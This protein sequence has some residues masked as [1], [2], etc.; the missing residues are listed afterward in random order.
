MVDPNTGE[1][2]V[3]AV[4]TWGRRGTHQ[5]SE[6]GTGPGQYDRKFEPVSNGPLRA[7]TGKP[8]RR[9]RKSHSGSHGDKAETARRILVFANP[10]SQTA[11]ENHTIQVGFDN[12]QTWPDEYHILLDGGRGGGYPSLT[13]IGKE[14]LGIVYEGS[15][16]DIVFQRFNLQEL[17]TP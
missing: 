14:Q 5:W 15:Q 1:V 9:P 3:A 13:R 4:W 2:F 6:G 10:H 7:T 12:G 8:G 11:R 17:L 16:A